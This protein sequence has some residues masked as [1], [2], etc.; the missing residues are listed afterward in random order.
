MIL[1]DFC[2][3]KFWDNE[4]IYSEN[5]DFTFCFENTVLIWVP[6]MVLW[7]ISPIWIYMLTKHNQSKLKLS[8]I[9]IVKIVTIFIILLVKFFVSI[10]SYFMI[11]FKILTSILISIEVTNIYRA[12]TEDKQFV[13]YFLSPLVL[14][15]SYVLTMILTN[16]ER[17]KGLKTSSLLFTFWSLL[18]L[19]SCI[20]LR[21]VILE[22]KHEPEKS[23]IIALITFCVFF[24]V[25]VLNLII[26]VLCLS[27]TTLVD[28]NGRKVLPENQVSLL[29]KLWFW[30]LNGLILTG[31]KREITR[32]DLW[33]VE[34]KES[35]DYNTKRFEKIWKKDAD[36]YIR[37]MR[38]SQ[39]I[40]HEEKSS[41]S[42]RTQNEEEEIALNEVDFV[43]KKKNKPSFGFALVK[44]FRGK[45]VAGSF[46]KLIYD[47]FQFVG[48]MIL[49]KLIKFIKEKEQ[50]VLVGIFLT[51]LLFFSSL[52][53]SFVLQHYFHRMFIVGA[54]IRTTIMNVVYKKV[55][56]LD[57]YLLLKK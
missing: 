29:S 2:G 37:Y 56:K 32:D 18:T 49:D 48:P 42:K 45:F 44:V 38:K 1:E 33:L 12:Y 11:I 34:E 21:S 31:F 43:M 47:L 35:S 30:W 10:L 41:R 36:E 23:D 16:Y 40:E 20:R 55:N 27:K 52:I 24:V 4:T 14:I 51:T 7:I 3:D 17:Y 39:D 25:L 57:W 15:I 26:S 5:P 22:Y 46:L 13:I 54:R 9:I 28:S 19:T 6:C 8:F 53:Q 50:N